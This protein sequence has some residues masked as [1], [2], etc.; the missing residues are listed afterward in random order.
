[1]TTRLILADGASARCLVASTRLGI[2]NHGTID[3]KRRTKQ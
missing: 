3:K 2:D 1:M